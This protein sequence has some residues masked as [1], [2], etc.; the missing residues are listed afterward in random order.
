M[1]IG[2]EICASTIQ[3]AVNA[4][5]GGATR[6][7][8]CDN[9]EG[10]GTT[11]SYATIEYCVKEL[12][13]E[14][15]VLVRPRAG[16]FA[17]S[18]EEFAVICKDVEMCKQLGANSAVVGFLK[19]NGELDA[20]RLE[21]VVKIASPMK[22]V[23]HRAFDACANKE[24]AIEQIINAGCSKVLTSGG[25]PTS[26]EG[27]DSL[28]K[29][30]KQVDGRIGV[31]AASGVNSENVTK[32]IRESGVQEVHSPCKVL[33]D[34]YSLTSVKEVEKFIGVVTRLYDYDIERRQ[35]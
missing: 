35:I 1:I 32:I 19:K 15:N 13:L 24:V 4:K 33:V 17:Y 5:A 31:I 6:I 8:I 10:G 9:L 16:D 14:T 25:A 26:A 30:V 18:E 28:A 2:I 27:I 20:E 34:N 23:C 21:M 12:G 29:I 11:P 3:S 7:E 22:V